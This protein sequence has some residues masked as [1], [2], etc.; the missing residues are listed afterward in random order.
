M[1]PGTQKPRSD[2]QTA[3]GNPESGSGSKPGS[4]SG[5]RNQTC[6][7]PNFY[8]ATVFDFFKAT[9]FEYSV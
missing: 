2:S 3:S 4:E 7:K 8:Q 1:G 5:T 6:K 9:V